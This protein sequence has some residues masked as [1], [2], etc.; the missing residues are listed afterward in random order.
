MKKFLI[1]LGIG[2]LMPQ[3]TAQTTDALIKNSDISWVAETNF[4]YQLEHP[5]QLRFEY[6]ESENTEMVC[7]GNTQTYKI[8]PELAYC[9]YGPNMLFARL[10]QKLGEDG[11]LE[12]YKPEGTKKMTTTEF[13]NLF[14]TIDTVITFFPETFEE[15][16]SI[17]RS[18][19][20]LNATS[21]RVRQV[22]F[23]NAKNN[24][25]NSQ[26][27]GI[28]PLVADDN[29]RLQPLF[30]AEFND[31]LAR[32]LN[33]NSPEVAWMK[34]TK[35]NY[36]FTRVRVLKGDTKTTFEAYFKDNVLN[37]KQAAYASANYPFCKDKYQLKKDELE[38]IYAS[39]QIDTVIVFDPATYK[40]TRTIV[41]RSG[42]N[43]DEI[44]DYR[45]VQ[46]WYFDHQRGQMQCSLEAIGPIVEIRNENGEFRYSKPLYFIEP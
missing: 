45:L 7:V 31:K 3:L 11:N 39:N 41:K 35:S 5:E 46:R 28:T 10:L 14:L 22:W 20:P 1:L 26:I 29:G 21:Y 12:V 44:T 30:Y 19:K 8:D 4:T 40:E 24:I 9:Q 25:L 17:V 32:A 37:E 38:A 13:G 36:D 33:I 16:L 42:L 43:Y 34:Q 27:V 23:Y 15:Q 2:F 6:K 18:E